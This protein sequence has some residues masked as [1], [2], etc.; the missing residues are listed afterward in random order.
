M[1]YFSPERWRR[2][3]PQRAQTYFRATSGRAHRQTMPQR[4]GRGRTG[5]AAGSSRNRSGSR[6][7]SEGIVRLHEIAQLPRVELSLRARD[8]RLS[9][10]ELR[11]VADEMAETRSSQPSPFNHDVATL[12]GLVSPTN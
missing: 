6:S 3:P 8:V 12:K 1:A 10:G 7:G 5:S 11:P 2:K 4:S 9:R